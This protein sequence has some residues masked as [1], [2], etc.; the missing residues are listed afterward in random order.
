M[1]K[2]S[3]VAGSNTLGNWMAIILM[4]VVKSSRELSATA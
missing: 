1:E 3:I 4:T 2:M